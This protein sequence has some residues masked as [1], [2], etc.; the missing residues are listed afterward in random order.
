MEAVGDRGYKL[1]LQEV[2]KIIGTDDF[3]HIVDD[4][5]IIVDQSI[6][7]MPENSRVPV[8]S[9]LFVFAGENH[10]QLF[11]GVCAKVNP[12]IILPPKF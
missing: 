11:E 2:M 6:T 3:Q 4:G 8:C 5:G 12:P 9:R 10:M 7:S 1:N